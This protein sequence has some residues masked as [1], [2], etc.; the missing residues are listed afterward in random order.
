V[1]AIKSSYEGEAR[2][3]TV[4]SEAEERSSVYRLEKKTWRMK[5]AIK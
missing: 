1:F 5:I 2:D 4:G 3:A